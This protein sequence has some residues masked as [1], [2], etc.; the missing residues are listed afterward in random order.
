MEGVLDPR[1][2][3]HYMPGEYDPGYHHH[4]H[5]QPQPTQWTFTPLSLDNP[6]SAQ[7]VIQDFFRDE[8]RL[9][10]I[11]RRKLLIVL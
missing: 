2:L 9:K 7:P 6:E 1:D 11:N 4:M 5:P 3:G 8:G 10:L